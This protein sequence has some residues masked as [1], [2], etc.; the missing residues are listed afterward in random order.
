M[1]T[2]DLAAIEKTLNSDEKARESFL[3]DPA[4]Y[5]AHQGIKV[6]P[7]TEPRLKELVKGVT[8]GPSARSA[9]NARV[10]VEVSVKVRF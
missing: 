5:F 8:A 2:V 10:D 7:E 4:A 3:K 1:A 9:T 6:A